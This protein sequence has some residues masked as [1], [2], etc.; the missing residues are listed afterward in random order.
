[1]Q[2][3]LN[4]DF[5]KKIFIEYTSCKLEDIEIDEANCSISVSNVGSFNPNVLGMPTRTTK[6]ADDGYAIIQILIW[7]FN[8][9]FQSYSRFTNPKKI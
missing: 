6:R 8:E 5:I 4:H 9:F 3:L 2:T 7:S 1:M